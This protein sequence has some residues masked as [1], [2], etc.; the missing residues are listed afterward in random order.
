MTTRQLIL[1]GGPNGAGK[2]TFSMKELALKGGVYLGADAIAAEISPDN[3]AAAAIEAG[4]I[5]LERFDQLIQTEQR[6]IVESTLAGKSLGQ[7]ISRAK[8][9]GFQVQ[10][11]FIF[12]DSSDTSLVRVR[13]RFSTGGHDVP[14]EDVR[15][16]FTRSI[17]NFWT[18]Y[19]P[20][21]DQ[22]LLI[23]NADGGPVEVAA[24][25]NDQLTIFRETLFLQFQ[26]IV[27]QA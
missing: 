12:V 11:K 6:L 17:V 3:P 4:R 26:Q 27:K 16:R 14:A 21:A 20:L 2:T 19:R 10:I 7:M 22:W 13:Q 8:I 23:Y 9:L 24:G 25:G 18:R 1:V 15:R 5:F